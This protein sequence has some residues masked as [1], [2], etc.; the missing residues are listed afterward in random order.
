MSVRG[1]YNAKAVRLAD[2]LASEVRCGRYPTGSHLPA[3]RILANTYGAARETIRRAVALL[4]QRRVLRRVPHRGV[5]ILGADAPRIAAVPRAL[6]TIAVVLASEPDTGMNLIQSGVRDYARERGYDV[7]TIISADDP[8]RPFQVLDRFA[9]VGLDGA[10]V[11]PYPGNEHRDV[12]ERLWPRGLPVVCVERRS[13]ALKVPSVEIDN[14]AGMYRAVRHLLVSQRRP[15]W[16]LSLRPGHHT[17]R[18]RYDG[19]C[20]AMMDA[21]YGELI[22]A[23][24]V[25]HPWSTDDPRYWHASDPWQQGY[26][27]AQQL[28]A[29]QERFWSVACLKDDIA[30]GVY[31]AAQE[32]G[33]TIGREVMVT[34]FDDHPYAAELDPPLTTVRQPFRDKGYQAAR[35]LDRVM[36]DGFHAPVQVTL[37]VELVVRRSG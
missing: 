16:Y 18:T 7:R 5:M 17:D 37:G 11:L 27:V 25:W 26:E 12:L 24:T 23:R 2:Q 30:W 15:V 32:R 3:E 19:Y 34:G 20:R 14:A 9:A 1:P 21:G 29:H 8:E 33:L 28:F 31:R 13:A 4:E 10:I 22:A 6:R 36:V 35:L